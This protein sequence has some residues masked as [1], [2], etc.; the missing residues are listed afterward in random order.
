MKLISG[1]AQPADTEDRHLAL[2]RR[3]RGLEQHV[4]RER[5]P[6]S[7]QILVPDQRREDVEHLRRIAARQQLALLVIPLALRQRREPRAGQAHGFL[8]FSRD[9]LRSYSLDAAV[10]WPSHFSTSRC[11]WMLFAG[12]STQ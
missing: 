9:V 11:H 12:L 5:H 6:A 7:I 8:A 3:Q 2:A 4:V 1:A 10:H